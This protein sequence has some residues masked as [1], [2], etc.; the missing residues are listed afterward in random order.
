[1][2]SADGSATAATISTAGLQALL[3]ESSAALDRGR[4]V[5]GIEVSRRAIQQAIELGDRV[6]E[7]SGLGL[8]ARQLTRSGEYEQTAAVC[9]QAAAILRELDD[10]PGLCDNMIV[11]ALALNEL[12]LSEEALD[13]LDVAHEVANRL[14]NRNLLYWVHNRIAVV[15][16]SMQ[17]HVRAK[18]FQQRALILVKGL[19]EDAR[20]CIINNVSDNAIGLAR[21][22][23]E[24]GDWAAADQAVQDGLKYAKKA[25][26]MAVA[27]KNPYREVLALDNGAVLLALDGDHLGSLRQLEEAL[28]LAIEH[29]Y[30]SLELCCRYH[31]ATVLLLQDRMQEAIPVLEA[32]LKRAIELS[33]RP[34]QLQVLLALSEALERT[35]CFELALRRHKQFVALERQLRSTVAATRVRMLAQLVDLETARLEAALARNEALQ[36]R[37]R[38]QELEDE[39]RAL[40]RRTM[41]LDR[42]VNEDALTRLSNRHH[43]EAELPRLFAEAYV[44]ARPLALVIL[45]I[46]HFK[47]V[48]DT[49]GHGVGDAVLVR[50][51]RLMVSTRRVGDLIGRLG[52]EEFLLALPGLDEPGAIDL[53]QRLRRTVETNDWA[54]IRPGLRVTVSLGICARSDEPDVD[55]LVERADAAMYRAKRAG[56]NRVEWDSNRRQG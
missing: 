44:Q 26:A 11:Q 41:D 5:E 19:D 28:R 16:S 43:L 45:D 37:A 52:G 34:T 56:R 17:D 46:D 3:D 48:N 6:R 33:E 49:F 50:L 13:A 2:K 39:N 55:A 21:Q 38:T 29:G 24:T 12:G 47:H 54:E 7:A 42:R 14:N 4:C 36:H 35:G 31:Q 15:L 8:L 30:H 10:Q 51:A 25:L 40:E 32:A 20:F 53:C 9:D 18:D 27:S 22:I 23:R 1:M